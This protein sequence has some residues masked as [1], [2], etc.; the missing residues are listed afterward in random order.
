MN[1]WTDEYMTWKMRDGHFD[2][3]NSHESLAQIIP[4]TFCA[5]SWLFSLSGLQFFAR[6]S[7]SPRTTKGITTVAF[8]S[9]WLAIDWMAVE[10]IWDD[11]HDTLKPCN[12]GNEGTIYSYIVIYT[13][14]PK[15]VFTTKFSWDW[16]K[17]RFS[18]TFHHSESS[19]CPTRQ[20]Q[21]ANT[22]NGSTTG[23]SIM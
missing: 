22:N 15:S 13:V 5:S 16:C 7:N 17:T 23:L 9:S 10:E 12:N 19:F 18:S 20:K 1:E 8:N 11:L 3:S 2:W 14:L 6:P 21:Y 4:F